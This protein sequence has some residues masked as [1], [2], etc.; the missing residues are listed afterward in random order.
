T[1]PESGDN[2][3]DSQLE[4]IFLQY[5]RFFGNQQLIISFM[6]SLDDTIKGGCLWV[7]C[8]LDLPVFRRG[9]RKGLGYPTLSV[10]IKLA[11]PSYGLTFGTLSPGLSWPWK[12]RANERR[13][14][15]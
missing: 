4:I 8:S 11:V 9:M 7:L 5:N 6:N 12:Y 1:L 15:G 10:P 2:T 14:L 13:K 3:H